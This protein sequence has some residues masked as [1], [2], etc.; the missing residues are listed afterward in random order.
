MPDY[1]SGT[2]Y[3]TV[4]ET[5]ECFALE[6]ETQESICYIISSTYHSQKYKPIKTEHK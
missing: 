1:Y 5:L 3:G 6:T 2:A 4:N